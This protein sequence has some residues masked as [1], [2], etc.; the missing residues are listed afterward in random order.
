MI[1]QVLDDLPHEF[2]QGFC[3][4]INASHKKVP[5]ILFDLGIYDL[6]TQEQL[7]SDKQ[8]PKS[9]TCKKDE[10]PRAKNSMLGSGFS[11]RGPPRWAPVIPVK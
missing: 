7:E 11:L 5:L 3:L 4:L 1:L 8:S 10:H 6:W 2:L 9:Y